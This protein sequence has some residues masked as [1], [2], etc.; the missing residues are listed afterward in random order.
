[1]AYTHATAGASPRPTFTFAVGKHIAVRS[2]IS[3]AAGKSR[4]AVG[5]ISLVRKD[6]F[7]ALQPTIPYSSA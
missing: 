4:Y 3:L 1:M 7:P 5:V 6:N 2:I